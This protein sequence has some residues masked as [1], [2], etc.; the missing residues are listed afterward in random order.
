MQMA[1]LIPPLCLTSA[2][3]LALSQRKHG[4]RVAGALILCTV[5][6]FSV[7]NGVLCWIVLLPVLLSSSGPGRPSR[8]RVLGAWAAG[9]AVNVAL[10]AY[11]YVQPPD[12]PPVLFV[13]AHPL[14]SI[15]YFISFLGSP[16]APTFGKNND[17]AA[18]VLGAGLLALFL[19]G[20]VRLAREGGGRLERALPWIAIG[21]YSILTAV[22][23]TFARV[24]FGNGQPLA[25]R[26]VT[27]SLYLGVALVGLI[28]ILLERGSGERGRIPVAGFACAGAMAIAAI[29]T[30]PVSLGQIHDGRVLRLQGKACLQFA[31]VI[32]DLP[33]LHV[34]HPRFRGLRDRILQLDRGG[35]LSPGLVRSRRAQ[36]IEGDPSAD[37]GE[38]VHLQRRGDVFKADGRAV[39]PGRGEPADAILLAHENA[40][41]ESTIFAVF[42]ATQMSGLEP[43]AGAGA[44]RASFAASKLP[45]D[46][47]SVSAWAFD[48]L[49]GKA[50]RLRGSPPLR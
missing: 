29:G 34:L 9:L 26:Y 21:A 41:G 30:W 36:D 5:A 25:S 2:L 32:E 47:V 13:F 37:C 16:L 39:L 38:F 40:R 49:S 27:F 33:G 22:M 11:G 20:C 23:T 19:G 15:H 3:R 46:A 28:A 10:Y 7:G 45:A 35:F 6:T 24:G 43:A 44:W 12:R 31:G 1:L 50:F 17:L 8:T 42:I 48:A 18:A 14:Q 4:L